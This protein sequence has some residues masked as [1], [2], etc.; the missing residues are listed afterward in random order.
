M[1]KLYGVPLFA[2]A[3]GALVT[4]ASMAQAEGELDTQTQTESD[5][6]TEMDTDLDTSTDMESDLDTDIDTTLDTDAAAE[7]EMLDSAVL[8]EIEDDAVTHQ[9]LTVSEIEGMDV[10]TSNDESIGEVEDVLG[11]ETGQVKAFVIGISDGVFD[12]DA[13]K[14]VVPADRLTLNAE[15]DRFDTQLTQ[16]DIEGFDQWTQ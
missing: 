10:Y 4:G 14:V 2:L 13:R 3:L 11:D 15:N 5:V 9:G 12:L 16:T 8:I 7:A 6:Q 1:N